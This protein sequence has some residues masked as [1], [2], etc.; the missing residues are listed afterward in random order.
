M[1]K[2]SNGPDVFNAFH[3]RIQALSNRVS[4]LSKRMIDTQ[5]GKIGI[6]FIKQL[7]DRTMLSE[8]IIKPLTESRAQEKNIPASEIASRILY[9]D[10]CAIDRESDKIYSD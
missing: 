6:F 5:T 1:L 9:V 2:K 4:D 7:T 10:D 3:E 8:Y